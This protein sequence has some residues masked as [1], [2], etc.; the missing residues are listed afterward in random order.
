MLKYR[1]DQIQLEKGFKKMEFRTLKSSFYNRRYSK[2][3]MYK[4]ADPATI[5]RE[6]VN[7]SQSKFLNKLSLT[8][9]TNA[10]KTVKKAK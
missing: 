5:L 1:R 9:I 10:I 7:R 8:K 6:I 3:K 2:S 4:E